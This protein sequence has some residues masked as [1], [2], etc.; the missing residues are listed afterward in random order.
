MRIIKKV[1]FNSEMLTQMA[2]GEEVTVVCDD[3]MQ[4]QSLSVMCSLALKRYPRE[5]VSKYSTTS[6]SQGT[7]YIVN[8]LAVKA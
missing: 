2:P 4:R 8:I 5:D 6:A 7:S 3:F 1:D